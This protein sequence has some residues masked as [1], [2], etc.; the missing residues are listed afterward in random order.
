M[1][2][3][4][5]RNPACGSRA[6]NV[7][8]LFGQNTHDTRLSCR[9]LQYLRAQESEDVGFRAFQV[10]YRLNKKERTDASR[11]LLILA[12]ENFRKVARHG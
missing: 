3:P 4:K 1:K 11:Y 5:K 2:H 7:V 10:A 8:H 6:S 9:K 12:A